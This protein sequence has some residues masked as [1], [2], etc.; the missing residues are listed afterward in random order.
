M[1]LYVKV[2]GNWLKFHCGNYTLSYSNDSY[3]ITIATTI[4][5]ALHPQPDPNPLDHIVIV[6]LMLNPTG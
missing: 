6:T 1:S 4:P 3:N 5:A 2:A